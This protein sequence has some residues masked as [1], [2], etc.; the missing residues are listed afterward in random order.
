MNRQPTGRVVIEAVTLYE[1]K[2]R[3]PK[4]RAKPVDF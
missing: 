4:N 1:G 2:D 3:L